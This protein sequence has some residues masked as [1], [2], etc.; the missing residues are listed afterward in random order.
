MDDRYFYN[1]L[2]SLSI[3]ENNESMANMSFNNSSMINQNPAVM[4][5]RTDTVLL[6]QSAD[7]STAK[8][9]TL[10]LTAPMSIVPS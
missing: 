7:R 1:P 9:K 2:N 10:K 5:R 8:L 4:A 3:S 6:D